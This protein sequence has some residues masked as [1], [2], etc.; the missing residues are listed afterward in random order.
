MDLF[1]GCWSRKAFP[2]DDAG[3][4]NDL[5]VMNTVNLIIQ[6]EGPALPLPQP[7]TLEYYRRVMCAVDHMTAH[8]PLEIHGQGVDRP[9]S[10]HDA[11]QFQNLRHMAYMQAG[12][13]AVHQLA[14]WCQY[15]GAELTFDSSSPEELAII[16]VRALRAERLALMAKGEERVCLSAVVQECVALLEGFA[17]TEP[18]GS[19]AVAAR[20]AAGRG[21]W[22]DN[23]WRQVIMWMASR[24]PT[25]HTEQ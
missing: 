14:D 7:F 15:I 2:A 3:I 21:D 20:S 19:A 11:I 6:T 9:S 4:L 5:L 16:L 24:L 10:P 17:G 13:D 1:L 18:S 25:T 8:Y 23:P 12:V 22:A